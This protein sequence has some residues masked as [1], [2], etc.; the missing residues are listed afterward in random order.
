MMHPQ[1]A[2]RV[3]SLVM[4]ICL[5]FSIPSARQMFPGPPERT[6]AMLKY[7]QPKICRRNP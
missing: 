3:L 6:C 5:S 4:T 2:H 1:D 7:D